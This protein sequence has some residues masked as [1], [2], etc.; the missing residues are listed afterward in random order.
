MCTGQPSVRSL[1]H[2]IKRAS[3]PGAAAIAWVAGCCSSRCALTPLMPKELV[4][5]P[6]SSPSLCSTSDQG[7]KAG[8]Q[9]KLRVTRRWQAV[10]RRQYLVRSAGHG[11]AARP[12]AHRHK[13]QVGLARCTGV[14]TA[15]ASSSGDT[16]YDMTQTGTA[17]AQP[18]PDP[19]TAHQ[20]R[21]SGRRL[22]RQHRRPAAAADP[23]ATAPPVGRGGAHVRVDVPQVDDSGRHAT[24]QRARRQQRP[25]DAGR[26]LSVPVACLHRFPSDKLRSC[27]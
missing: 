17:P 19:L 22:P 1:Q 11:V 15:A 7:F 23:A 12:T 18:E 6:H 24:S 20:H 27:M 13:E 5:A 4:P 9:T 2:N 14:A 10:I 26:A 3:A 8:K 25:R 16:P 21:R